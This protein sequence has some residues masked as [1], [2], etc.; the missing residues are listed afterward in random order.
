MGEV[1]LQMAANLAFITFS[2]GHAE[3]KWMGSLLRSCQYN[4][5]SFRAETSLGCEPKWTEKELGVGKQ[6]Y[7]AHKKQPLPLGLPQGPTHMHNVGS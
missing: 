5:I 3:G 6:G 1:P 2:Q 4:P 7:L